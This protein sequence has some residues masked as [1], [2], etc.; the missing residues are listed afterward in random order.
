MPNIAAAASQLCSSASKG[1]AVPILPARAPHPEV[2]RIGHKCAEL[3]F[4][5]GA[6]LP[7]SGCHLLRENS[8]SRFHP[9]PVTV[10]KKRNA[11]THWNCLSPTRSPLGE[12]KLMMQNANPGQSTVFETL[13]SEEACSSQNKLGLRDDLVDDFTSGPKPSWLKRRLE[14][15]PTCRIS[16]GQE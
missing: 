13:F 14:G 9:G 12:R 3:G 6:L 5:K 15:W 1:D 7:T 16:F 4:D 10:G 2:Q 11:L 8:R